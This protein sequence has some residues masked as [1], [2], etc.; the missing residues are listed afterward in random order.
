MSD[1]HR[2][3]IL[4]A[5]GVMVALAIAWYIRDV[6]LLIYVSALF[7]VVLGPGVQWVQK[8]HIGKWHPNRGLAMLLLI[9]A[10]I[11]LVTIFFVFALPP[12]FRDVQ[13]FSADLPGK[14]QRLQDRMQH[15]PI[16]RQID[17]SMLKEHAAAAVGGAVGLFKGVAGGVVGFFSFL[18]LM[19]YFIIDGQRAFEWALSLFSPRYRPQLRETMGR[20]DARVSKWLLGQF[21]LML[22]LGSLSAV[23]FGFLHVKYFVA[24]AVFMG[25][26]N[27]VPIVG[28]VVSVTLAAIVSAFDSWT[29]AIAVL[30]F[31]LIYQQVENAFLTP[32]IMKSTVDLPALAVIIALAIGGSLAG[33]LGALVA[34]PTAA[35]IAVIVDEYVV[36]E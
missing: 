1:N 4:F 8:L 12:I 32:K 33:I 15:W 16:A 18:I 35:L 26:A 9:A 19:A 3:D 6:L 21:A 24:L 20:A 23:V 30:V 13:Q 17:P 5:F 11:A 31:N 29:K 22:I 28:P 10:F 34:V 2:S 36:K 7:A 14:L 25:V 27:I